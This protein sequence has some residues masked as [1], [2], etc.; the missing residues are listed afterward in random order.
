MWPMIC[1]GLY[2]WAGFTTAISV[3]NS[4]EFW[5]FNAS[6]RRPFIENLFPLSFCFILWPLVGLGELVGLRR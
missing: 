1:L 6:S 5:E 2:I 4:A 3:Y